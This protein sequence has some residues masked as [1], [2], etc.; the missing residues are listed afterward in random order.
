M[1]KAVTNAPQ[2]GE[3]FPDGRDP[4]RLAKGLWEPVCPRCGGPVKPL[5]LLETHANPKNQY[6]IAKY[7]QELMAV[8]LGRNYGIPSVALR[9]S[10]VQGPHQSFRNA[11]SGVLRIFT[12]QMMKDRTPSIFED[13]QQL[14]DYVNVS[15]VARANRLVMESDEVNYEVFNVGGGRGYTVLDFAGIV[16]EA[17][18]KNIRLQIFGRVS[19]RRHPSQHFRYFQTPAARMESNGHPAGK[20]PRVCGLDSSPETGK[21]LRGGSAGSDAQNGRPEEVGVN[22]GSAVRATRGCG[23]LEPML[24]RL[25]ARVANRLIPDELRQGRIL[26]VGCGSRAYFLA[27]T[28]FKEKFAVDQLTPSDTPGAIA[29]HTLDLNREP[30]LPFDD[31]FFDAITMLAVIEHLDPV[32]LVA[33]FRETHRTLRRGGEAGAHDTGGV[34]RRCIEGDGPGQPGQRR[35]DRRTQVC[36]YASVVGMVFWHGEL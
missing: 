33:L 6:S 2:D 9:Y 13:G 31:G 24:A 17:L 18:G 10:I 25:R 36:L 16:A 30:R 3:V 5:P 20:R 32:N 1:A 35:G 15:D 23:L 7:S 4:Q 11:Y 14:R 29:W 19:G 8:A 21:G 27:H 26:D 28:S 34:V 12:L 22:K